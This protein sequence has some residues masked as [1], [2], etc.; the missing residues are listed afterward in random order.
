MLLANGGICVIPNVNS[1][2]RQTKYCLL[3]GKY[4]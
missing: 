1:C 2:N 4:V 3:Q